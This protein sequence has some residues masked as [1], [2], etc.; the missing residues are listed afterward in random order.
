[1]KFRTDSKCAI[2]KHEKSR[3]YKKNRGSLYNCFKLT[4]TQKS[5]PN[6]ETA[7]LLRTLVLPLNLEKAYMCY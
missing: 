2:S 1:M 3:N 5:G 7:K 6:T 4:N